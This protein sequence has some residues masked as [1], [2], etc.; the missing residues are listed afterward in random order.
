L[1]SARFTARDALF[2]FPIGT[3]IHM[4]YPDG[5][6]QS[7][8]FDLDEGYT[9]EGLARGI[10]RV[11]VIGAQGYAPPTPIALSRNQDV[12]LMVFSYLDMGVIASI[13][14]LLSVGL[15]WYG[16]PYIFKQIW[17][18]GGRLLPK[19]RSM[20]PA[21]HANLSK[22]LSAVG[23]RFHFRKRVE[24]LV[25]GDSDVASPPS[26]EENGLEDLSVDLSAGKAQKNEIESMV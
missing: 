2:G 23:A 12:E 19:K 17:D 20:Q 5:E 9:L 3:G 26:D 16:R 7:Y 18:F 8:S 6:T 15:L 24:P 13:G 14:L 4:E 11:T 21:G 22:R 1:Y 25:D 10:Y